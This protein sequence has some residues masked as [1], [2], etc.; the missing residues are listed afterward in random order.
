[1]LNFTPLLVNSQ[2]QN[3]DKNISDSF[4]G[5]S[6]LFCEKLNESQDS[7]YE[8]QNPLSLNFPRISQKEDIEN[9][10]GPGTLESIN[11]IS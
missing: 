2:A 3:F 6:V 10:D 5:L 1:M 8:S 7:L 11:K 4:Q 9:L